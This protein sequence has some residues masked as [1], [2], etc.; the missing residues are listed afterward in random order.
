MS[1]EARM[2]LNSIYLNVV[3]FNS[4]LSKV[5]L[6]D[7]FKL[8]QFTIGDITDMKSID[9]LFPDE[10]VS[11][12]G[13]LTGNEFSI[14]SIK[15]NKSMLDTPILTIYVRI[16]QELFSR[17]QFTK[18]SMQSLG[19]TN[20]LY[21]FIELY[22][23]SILKLYGKIINKVATLVSVF[24]DNECIWHRGADLKVGLSNRVEKTLKRHGIDTSK[25]FALVGNYDNSQEY[26]YMT[27]ELSKFKFKGTLEKGRRTLWITEVI[28]EVRDLVDNVPELSINELARLCVTG[29][30]GVDSDFAGEYIAGT[31][32]I[33]RITV[34]G[35]TVYSADVYT[36][37]VPKE[38]LVY[39]LVDNKNYINLCIEKDDA[40]LVLRDDNTFQYTIIKS[41]GIVFIKGQVKGKELILCAVDECKL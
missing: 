3:H 26:M 21:T 30:E 37:T 16:P 41:D 24:K 2:V 19:D 12:I 36:L 22:D 17:V 31:S 10:D 33:Q 7:Y 13:E 20:M 40:S 9:N 1:K 38:S 6:D 29:F 25:P 32:K 15:N 34:K 28:V 4:E 11:V 35:E 39:L 23:G 5:T 14:S 27:G 18:V 8:K